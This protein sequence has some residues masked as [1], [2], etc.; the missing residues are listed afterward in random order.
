V[1]AAEIAHAVVDDGYHFKIRGNALLINPQKG[2]GYFF[3]GLTRF[4]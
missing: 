3:I 2:T 1:D 4:G